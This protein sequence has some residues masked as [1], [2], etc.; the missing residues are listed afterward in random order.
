MDASLRL[1]A[2]AN[3]ELVLEATNLLGTDTILYQQVDSAGTLEP[4]AW[5]RNDR[6]YQAG[7]RLSVSKRGKGRRSFGA[8][9]RF[10]P[11]YAGPAMGDK[12]EIMIVGGGTAG[13]SEEHPSEFQSLMCKSY[14]ELG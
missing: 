3:I 8:G 13:R 7:V 14:A 1:R 11:R 9:A 2:T 6:R 12:F 10:L 4:N 5:F